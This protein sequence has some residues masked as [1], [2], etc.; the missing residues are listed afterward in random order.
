M[1]A[2][3]KYLAGKEISDYAKANYGPYLE[4]AKKLTDEDA[5]AYRESKT[6]TKKPTAE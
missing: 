3:V 2:C 4:A 5:L 6:K 1:G